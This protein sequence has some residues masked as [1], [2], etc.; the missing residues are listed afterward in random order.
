VRYLSPEELLLL[1]AEAL[2]ERVV[3]DC[4][5]AARGQTWAAIGILENLATRVQERDPDAGVDARS[6][7]AELKA[8][9][10]D[11]EFSERAALA[12]LET[13]EGWRRAAE[14]VRRREARER[15]LRRPTYFG[16]IFR[17]DPAGD[18]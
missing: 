1:V 4:G 15:E 9:S 13:A 17:R 3:P 7:D 2:R 5:P 10:S 16:E 11:A 8:G 14:A 12:E 6:P 18:A